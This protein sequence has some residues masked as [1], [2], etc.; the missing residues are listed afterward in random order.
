MNERKYYVDN[1]RWLWILILIPFHAAMAFNSWESNY[2]WLYENKILS[3]IPI[4]ISPWYMPMLFVLAGMSARF[5]LDRRTF[6]QFAVERVSKL[7]VPLI[8]GIVTI[9][10]VMTFYADKF[11]NNYNGSFLEHYKVFFTNVSDLTGNDGYLTPAHLWFVLFLFLISMFS[12][13]LIALQKKFLPKLSFAN[14]KTFLLPVLV[15]FPLIMN[16]VLNFGGKSIGE[17]LALFLLGYYI[18]SEEDVLKRMTKY[19][20]VYLAIMLVSDIILTFIFVWQGKQTGLLVTI[21]Y[22]CASWFGILGFIG[23]ARCIFNQNNTFTKY[24]SSRSFLFYIFHFGWLVVFQY[25]LSKVTESVAVLFGVAVVG[26]YVM[27]F[28]TCEIIRLI[29]G[30]RCLFGV[31]IK[32]AKNEMSNVE[33]NC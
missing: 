12:L 20:Y 30:L 26:S 25:Y 11:H 19:R 28:L 7:L 5:S 22:T 15:L 17:N 3:S 27:T 4:F 31:K 29:P 21:L 6:K 13:L 23:L 10:A 18:F 24:M 33:S 2:I 32:K 16:P 9:V 8:T 14:A 1:L